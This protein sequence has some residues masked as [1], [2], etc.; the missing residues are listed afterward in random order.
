MLK[1]IGLIACWYG[2]YP[3][4]FPYFIHSCGF[5]PTIDF[6]L[7]TDNLEI[8]PHKPKNVK[9][10]HM[11]L[12][13]IIELASQKLGFKVNVDFPYKLCDFRPAFGIIF[14]EFIK[15]YDF[16]G[17]TDIDV[18][19]GC[20]REFIPSDILENY[21]FISARHDYVTG[22]FALYKNNKKLN[23]LF[24]RSKDYKLVFSTSEHYCFDECNFAHDALRKGTSILVV[25]TPIES[26]TEVVKKAELSGEIKVHF[27]FILVE[28]RPGRITFNNGH[29]LYKNH[30]EGLMYHLIMLKYVF[31]P[32]KPVIN[33][34]SK[35]YISPNRIYHSR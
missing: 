10:I 5:N 33:I 22:C 3:W 16:W 30:F 6:I 35:F 18:I 21:D 23:E 1:T 26:F 4:Y 2:P 12:N 13:D 17:Q 19:Y 34:P 7:F 32:S 24:R 29:I 28:G 8:V 11:A 9:I 25:D 20:I 14:S 31:H 15:D 27:D